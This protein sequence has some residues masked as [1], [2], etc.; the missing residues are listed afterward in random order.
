MKYIGC[1]SKGY[2]LAEGKM[3]V[4][5]TVGMSSSELS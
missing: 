3:F 2:V 4:T 1:A 5:R